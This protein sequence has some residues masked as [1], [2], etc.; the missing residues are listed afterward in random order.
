MVSN[1]S[2]SINN[3]LPVSIILMILMCNQSVVLGLM[4][5]IAGTYVGQEFGDNLPKISLVIEEIL[6]LGYKYLN[7]IS[8]S[9]NNRKK[10]KKES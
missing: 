3:V 9:Y 6:T 5:I 1:T 8:S 4:G 2:K 7:D 10:K